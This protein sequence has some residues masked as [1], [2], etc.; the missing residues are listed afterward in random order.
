MKSCQCNICHRELKNPQSQEIGMGPVCFKKWVEVH[1][2]LKEYKL[3][4][5]DEIDSDDSII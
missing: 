3:I 1:D 2:K 5:I 4:N